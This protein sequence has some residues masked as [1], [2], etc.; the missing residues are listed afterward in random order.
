MGAPA[1]PPVTTSTPSPERGKEEVDLAAA[2]EKLTPEQEHNALHF[3][4]GPR[5]PLQHKVTVQYETPEGVQ[6]LTFLIRSMDGRAIDRI[7]Q[8]NVS[9]ATG[10]VDQITANCQIVAEATQQ[11]RD[12]S[13]ESVQPKSE[14]FRTVNPE[15]PPLASAADALEAR[16]KDQLGLI[17]GIAREVRRVSGWDAEKVGTAERVLVDPTPKQEAAAGN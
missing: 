13:G 7:E 2:G 8:A 14:Q 11:I 4:L 1:A 15:Q 3:L 17:A 6:P 12:E 10:R 5:R 9:E 16:F